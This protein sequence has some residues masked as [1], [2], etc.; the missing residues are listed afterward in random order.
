MPSGLSLPGSNGW[1]LQKL[2]TLATHPPQ[3][4]T[5]T[6]VRHLDLSTDPKLI[7]HLAPPP[8][9]LI[10][11][12]TIVDYILLPQASAEY[13]VRYNGCTFC[14]VS[15]V[16]YHHPPP[17]PYLLRTTTTF[18]LLS[19]SGPGLYCLV[20]LFPNHRLEVQFGLPSHR[21]LEEPC[22]W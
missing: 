15:V 3:N 21:A 16:H 11:H 17:P 2:P 1:D 12:Q 5:G 4:A 7:L 6:L 22:I 14:N 19:P 13:L 20:R 10:Y 8:R 18:N 9:R